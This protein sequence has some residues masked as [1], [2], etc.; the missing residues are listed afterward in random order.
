MQNGEPKYF[1]DVLYPRL[2][3]ADLAANRKA[4]LDLVSAEVNRIKAKVTQF[5]EQAK[6]ANCGHS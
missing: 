1:G 6:E 2:S 4:Y 5:K 3:D